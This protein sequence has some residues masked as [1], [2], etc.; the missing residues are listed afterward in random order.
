MTYLIIDTSATH[1]G[2]VDCITDTDHWAQNAHAHIFTSF[3]VSVFNGQE[4]NR[5]T[6]VCIFFIPLILM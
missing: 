4:I 2:L 5:K 6:S 1:A 3:H